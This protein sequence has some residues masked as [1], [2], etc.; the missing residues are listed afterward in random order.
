MSTS[1][2]LAEEIR[3]LVIARL[4]TFPKDRA[5]S[6]GNLGEFSKDELIDHVKKGDKVGE[7]MIEM[8]LE[9]LRMLKDDDFLEYITA[10][11]T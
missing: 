7:T 3:K 5:V 6:V 9:Y 1:T 11:E 4:E 8:D 2:T 10:D